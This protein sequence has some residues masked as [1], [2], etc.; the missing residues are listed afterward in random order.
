MKM[1]KRRE[2][3]EE[4]MGIVFIPVYPG[5]KPND[6]FG[7]FNHM[8]VTIDDGVAFEWHRAVLLSLPDLYVINRL[9]L[10]KTALR[11][12]RKF[13]SLWIRQGPLLPNHFP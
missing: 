12:R 13:L 4:R 3:I 10:V 6:C 5:H 2:W 11:S 8:S 7:I 9:Y 1:V